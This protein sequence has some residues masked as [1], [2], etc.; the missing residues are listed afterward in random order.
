MADAIR[1][2]ASKR[3]LA[4]VAVAALA[5]LALL[6]SRMQSL[7]SGVEPVAWDRE[8]CAHCH[9]HVGDPRFAAQLQ[10]SD[11]SVLN[12]DDPG[13]LFSYVRERRP[14]VHAMYFHDSRSER[15]LSRA[16]AGFVPAPATPMGYGLAATGRDAPGAMSYEAA[17]DRVAA[18]P[19]R[20][21]PR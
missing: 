17:F 14:E 9:M 12:F 19:A 5:A 6:V 21:V 13:C 8:A 18:M 16:E 4:G 11:G 2:K 3:T 10:T 20:E 1:G 7:P 15:W